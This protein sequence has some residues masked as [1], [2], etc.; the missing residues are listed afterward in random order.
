MPTVIDRKGRKVKDY[1]YDN[2]GRRQARDHADRIGGTVMNRPHSTAASK[3]FRARPKPY[4]S[5]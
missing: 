1:P 2:A 4:R 3:P 5:R